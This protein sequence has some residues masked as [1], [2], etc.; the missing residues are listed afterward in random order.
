MKFYRIRISSLILLVCSLLTG[1]T[2][3]APVHATEAVTAPRESCPAPDI[4]LINTRHLPCPRNQRSGHREALFF[5]RQSCRWSRSTSED[6][7]RSLPSEQGLCIYIHGNRMSSEDAIKQGMQVYRRIAC[8]APASRF[9]IWS[10]P[11]DRIHGVIRDA[12]VKAARAD[13]E[14]FYVA[15]L[16]NRLPSDTPHQPDRI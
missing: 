4:W 1:S 8:A 12:E 10:W 5:R 11:S 16:L 9:V 6:F 13:G 14:G 7:F 15:S 3:G 2:R